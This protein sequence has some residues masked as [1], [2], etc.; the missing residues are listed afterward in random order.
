M[1]NALDRITFISSDDK[2]VEFEKDLIKSCLNFT[3]E[4]WGEGIVTQATEKTLKVF[5]RFLEIH[6]YEPKNANF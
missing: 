2:E 1:S 3:E 6:L 4:A 5:K